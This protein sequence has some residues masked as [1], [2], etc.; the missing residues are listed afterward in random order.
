MFER[1]VNKDK[2][3]AAKI[4]IGIPSYNEAE[5]IARPTQGASLGLVKYF[6]EMKPVIICCDNYSPDGTEDVFLSTETEV[7]KI[8]ITTPPNTPGKGYNIENMLRKALELGVETLICVDAD[9]ESLTPEWIKYFGESIQNGYDYAT[10]L[11]SRHKYDGTITNNICFP[12]IYGVFGRNVRQPIGGDFALSRRFMEYLVKR[13]WH[14]TTM[15]YGIDIFMTMNAVVGG[16]KICKVGLGAKIHKPSAPK[17]GPMFLQVVSTA[18]LMINK[19]IEKWRDIKDIRECPM[20]GLKELGEPQDL[21]VDRNSIKKQALAG[22][23]DAKENLKKY[24]HPDTF[25]KIKAVFKSDDFHALDAELWMRTVYEMIAAFQKSKHRAT[26]VESLRGLYFG[27]VFAFMNKT[28]EQSTSEAEKE[29]LAQADCFF[30][31][32]DYLLKLIS[33]IS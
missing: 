3:T 8:Y 19:H 4:A 1:E 13:I 24:L 22:F 26:L 27:R 2:V 14:R 7:P 17:L 25:E 33:K 32:K 31:H 6:S 23:G 10:P 18:F 9:L 12:L 5:S 20:F 28:W 21:T 29:I 16:F 30:K 11:Y 15:E